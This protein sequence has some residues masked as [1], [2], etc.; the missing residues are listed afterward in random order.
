[1][2]VIRGTKISFLERNTIMAIRVAFFDAKEYEKTA[3]VAENKYG[4]FDIIFYDTKLTVD[5]VG[6]ARGNDAVCVF[7][8]DIIDSEVINRLVECNIPIL[9]LRCSGYNNV[10]LDYASGRIRVVRVPNYSP[11]AVAEHAM[12]LLL[13]SIRRIHKAY[14]RTRDYNFSLSGLT[15]FELHGRTVGVVGTG[16]IGRVFIDICKGFGM[17]VVA[18]DKYPS[19]NLG[20]EYVSFE[21]LCKLSDVISFHCPLNSETKHIVNNRTISLMKKGVI[22][23]N[24]SR[25]GIID[26]ETLLEGIKSRHIGAAC[27]DV[28]EEEAEVFFND[29]SGH[30]LDDDTLLRLISMPNV[31]VTSH[32]AFLTKEALSAIAVTTLNN[33]YE[34]VNSKRCEN[35][36]TFIESVKNN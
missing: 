19:E 14:I 34:T 10:D 15:G 7:V 29:R 13:T 33:I 9:A 22:I 17:N 35:E 6:L 31:I 3:F 8:N 5:T 36:I 24:T 4:E 16:Q 11:Y 18:C 23:V 25:G 28:Y 20:V 2:Q 30:I 27:L 1:M 12:A 21:E 26:S 32:Q